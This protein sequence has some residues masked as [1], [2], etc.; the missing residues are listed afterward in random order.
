MYDEYRTWDI[1]RIYQRGG[2]TRR[3]GFVVASRDDMRGRSVALLPGY[4]PVEMPELP[5]YLDLSTEHQLKAFAEPVRVRVLRIIQNQPATAK[6]IADRLGLSPGTIGYHLQ[7]LED[8]GLAKIV[9][10]RLIRGI[11]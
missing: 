5:T 11:V 3:Q 1:Y 2:S 9:A 6:Q 10:R 7:V 4:V 8:A